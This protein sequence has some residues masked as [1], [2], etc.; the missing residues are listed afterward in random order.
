MA[1]YPLLFCRA[2]VLTVFAVA[3]AGKARSAS[4]F[5]GFVTSIRQLAILPERVAAPA[6]LAVVAGEGA[7]VVL[8]ALPAT[9]RAGFAL[10]A[11]LLAL[12]VGIVVRAVRGGVFAEC[13]CFGSKGS[14]MGQAMI[15]RNVLLLCAAVPGAALGASV[16]AGRPAEAVAALAAGALGAWGFTRWY[17]RIVA[18]LMRRLLRPAARDAG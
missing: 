1:D 17:D 8:L 4:G 5:K 7:A 13:R 16:P 2:L 3:F 15:V 10:A 14:V 18:A 6:G 11:A 9:V 12:F